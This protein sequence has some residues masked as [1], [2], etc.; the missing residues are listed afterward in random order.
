MPASFPSA[1]VRE[2]QSAAM[3][4]TGAARQKP[5][6][7]PSRKTLRTGGVYNDAALP[8][9]VGSH[10]VHAPDRGPVVERPLEAKERGDLVVGDPAME[11][12]RV[13]AD[14]RGERI[15]DSSEVRLHG[16][17]ADH[18]LRPADLDL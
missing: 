10:E 16:V 11:V 13:L 2:R 12:G 6:T 8:L 1:A 18:H 15:E 17:L 9:P 5:T 4:P 7:S 14:E 3:G